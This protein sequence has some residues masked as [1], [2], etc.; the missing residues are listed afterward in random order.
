MPNNLQDLF[1]IIKASLGTLLFLSSFF[2]VSILFKLVIDARGILFALSL[3]IIILF[4]L[5]IIVFYIENQL[6]R[7]S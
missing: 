5:S 6:R 4:I 1:I 2:L 3:T 7:K